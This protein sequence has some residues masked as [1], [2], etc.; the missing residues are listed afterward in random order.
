MLTASQHAPALGHV[1]SSCQ[2]TSC[3][4]LH[5]IEVKLENFLSEGGTLLLAFL[6][7]EKFR[8]PDLLSLAFLV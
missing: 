3:V 1:A 2:V 6:K 4:H 8:K 5:I 7:N